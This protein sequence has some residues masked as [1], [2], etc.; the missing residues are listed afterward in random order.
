MSLL[1]PPP[2]YNSVA[3]NATA[4]PIALGRRVYWARQNPTHPAAQRYLAEAR[5]YLLHRRVQVQ[6]SPRRP[7]SSS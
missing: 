3:I 7:T 5:E 1:T 4:Y 6:W 2:N